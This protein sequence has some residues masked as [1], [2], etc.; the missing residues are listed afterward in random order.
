MSRNRIDESVENRLM[1]EIQDM[2]KQIEEL[3]ANQAPSAIGSIVLD[4]AN[5]TIAIKDSLGNTVGIFFANTGKA[6]FGQSLDPTAGGLVI[7]TTGNITALTAPIDTN[8]QLILNSSDS[9]FNSNNLIL[10]P[11]EMGFFSATPVTKPTVTGSRG[12]NAALASLLTA[13]ANLGL[14]TDSSS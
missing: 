8:S 4:Q 10:T 2:K 14:I 12:G 11:T 6:I 3:K 1:K 9:G 5:S 13:L 7:D